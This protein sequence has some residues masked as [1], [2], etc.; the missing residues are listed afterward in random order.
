M[1]SERASN[2]VEGGEG[3]VTATPARSKPVGTPLPSA[4]PRPF[5]TTGEKAKKWTRCARQFFRR[6]L[7]RCLR[8]PPTG[9]LRA[10]SAGVCADHARGVRVA[11]ASAPKIRCVLRS[12]F[13]HYTTLEEPAC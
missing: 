10:G 13:F 6:S 7:L 1:M 8:S 9:L 11:A 4:L 3:G 12:V 2:L 5:A